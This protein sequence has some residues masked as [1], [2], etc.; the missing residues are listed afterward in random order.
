MRSISSRTTRILSLALLVTSCGRSPSF[1]ER[2]KSGI[3]A[4]QEK[5][6]PDAVEILDACARENP[7]DFEVRY[8][9]ARSQEEAQNFTVA[10]REWDDVLL[11]RPELPE[12]H[13]RK[14]NALAALGR[15]DDAIASWQGAVDRDPTFARAYYNQGAAYENLEKWD[16][17]AR[18][19]VLATRA[20]STFAPAWIDLGLLFQRA[21]EWEAALLSFDRAIRLQPSF[22]APRLNRI[23]ILMQLGRKADAIERIRELEESGGIDTL[24]ADSLR[25]LRARLAD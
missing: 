18:C 4:F 21:E 3:E 1:D 23:Q 7:R 20:D 10:L 12:A 19:Y 16:D 14:G 6:I 11:I 5:R 9:L 15:L 2:K 17:A 22:T 13:Y 8:Y 25:A 24:L